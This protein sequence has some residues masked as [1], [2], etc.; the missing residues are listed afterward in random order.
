MLIRLL[1]R[2]GLRRTVEYWLVRLTGFSLLSWYISRDAGVPYVPTLLLTC[3]GR[4][5][6]K[7]ET[8]PLFYFEDGGRYLLIG[9]KGGAP[10]HPDWYRNL[11]ANPQA[12]VRIRRR[13]IPVLASVAEGEERARLFEIAANRWPTYRRYVERAAPREIPVVVLTPRT[14]V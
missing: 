6:G 4:R 9:S 12:W 3:I 2:L 14:A 8:I 5:S 10:E 11:R 1:N 7:R 13:E